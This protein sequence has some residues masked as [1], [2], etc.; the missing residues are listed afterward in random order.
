[1]PN[2]ILT[3]TPASQQSQ[4]A[5]SSERLTKRGVVRAWMHNCER[6]TDCDAEDGA[7]ISAK[8]K[9]IWMAAKPEYVAHY[10]IPL[11]DLGGG[12]SVE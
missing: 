2:S 11:Y 8:S 10:T 5:D 3:E 7:V 1:M 4:P 9:E 6:D 12:A